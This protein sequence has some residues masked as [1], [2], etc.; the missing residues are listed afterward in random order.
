MSATSPPCCPAEGPAVSAD[1]MERELA[2][3]R[4]LLRRKVSVAAVLTVLV[5]VSSLP[6]MLGLHSLP[7]LPFWFTSPWTQ[8]ILT[9][10]VLFWCGRDF[11]TGAVSAFRQ[12]FADMNTL[13]AAGTGIAY[14]TSLFTTLFPQVLVAEGLP[15]DV[16]YETV[17]VIL[18]LVLLGRLLVPPLLPLVTQNWLFLQQH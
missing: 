17:A 3:E 4:T 5:M 9:T 16:Y 10:P 14:L 6:H 1:G 2:R 11:F 12:H 8:L 7:L 13:V 15:A 18:T